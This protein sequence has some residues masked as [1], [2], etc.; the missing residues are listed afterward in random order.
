MPVYPDLT[1]FPSAARTTSVNSADQ[2]M[3]GWQ[4]KGVRLYVDV[5]A[6]AGT[7]TL[8]IK[9]QGL[10]QAS[11]DYYDIPGAAFPQ[12]TAVVTDI[13]T[14]YPGIAETA[15][16]TVSDVLPKTWRVVATIGG[17]TPSFTFSLGA[18]IIP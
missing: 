5:T 17:T 10:D 3:E 16:E 6:V 8:D 2:V 7:P 11:G 14:V 15:N 4:G 12:I 18:C 13:L 9:V 1:I